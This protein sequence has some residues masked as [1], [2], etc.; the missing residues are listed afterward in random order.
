MNEQISFC[1]SHV[2]HSILFKQFL[3]NKL[4]FPELVINKIIDKLCLAVDINGYT[5]NDL[6]FH[7]EILKK[8]NIY[9]CTKKLKRTELIHII[10]HFSIPLEKYPLFFKGIQKYV[11]QNISNIKINEYNIQF[12]IFNMKY[13]IIKEKLINF[14]KINLILRKNNKI[15]IYYNNCNNFR[16]SPN[17]ID[18]EYIIC[19]YIHEKQIQQLNIIDEIYKY[20]QVKTV[21][22]TY[23][24]IYYNLNLILSYDE[25]KLLNKIFEF[26]IL[27]PLSI[28]QYNVKKYIFKNIL[29]NI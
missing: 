24:N 7:I 20:L 22:Y 10:Q 12:E 17:I 6:K 14:N 27:N 29:I 8:Q 21:I 15:I 9:T 18:L 19:L 3:Y 28:P 4:P 5:N 26:K 16:I 23:I 13:E 1:I 11:K 2:D 25:K